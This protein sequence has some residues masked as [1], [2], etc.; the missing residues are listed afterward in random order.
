[1]F[2]EKG[3]AIYALDDYALDKFDKPYL[4]KDISL[5]SFGE[6]LLYILVII[7]GV[8]T[9]DMQINPSEEVIYRSGDKVNA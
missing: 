4:K 3:F 9:G 6:E 7:G 1:M 8:I 2:T 5:L